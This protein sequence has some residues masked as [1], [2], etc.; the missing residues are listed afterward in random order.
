M[1]SHSSLGAKYLESSAYILL[2]IIMFG[3]GRVFSSWLFNRLWVEV[4][5]WLGVGG[6]SL[7]QLQE[8]KGTNGIDHSCI[9]NVTSEK[10]VRL[11]VWKFCLFFFSFLTCFK[12]QSSE[13][14]PL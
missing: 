13:P 1:R 3:I 12:H 2:A 9:L 11:T 8:G 6:S 5:Y 10:A 14:K 7:K 4:K